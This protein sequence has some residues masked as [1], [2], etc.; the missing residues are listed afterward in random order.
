MSNLFYYL[1]KMVRS[2]SSW[3]DNFANALNKSNIEEL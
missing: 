1:S 2:I 3:A